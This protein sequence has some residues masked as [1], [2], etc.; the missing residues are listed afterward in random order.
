MC[1]RLFLFVF[2]LVT[3]CV[4]HRDA[5]PTAEVPD[6]R[7]VSVVSVQGPPKDDLTSSCHQL[8]KDHLGRKWA[9][10]CV[11]RPGSSDY[12]CRLSCDDQFI[13]SIELEHARLA[14]EFRLESSRAESFAVMRIEG[15][16]GTGL[17][18]RV[19]HWYRLRARGIHN[20]GN[21]YVSGYVTG[22]GQ[23]FDRE[24]RVALDLLEDGK[25]CLRATGSIDV[26]GGGAGDE[27]L[28]PAPTD[29]D[30][31]L[32]FTADRVAEYRWDVQTGTFVADDETQAAG[33]EQMMTGG[34]DYLVEH[35]QPELTAYALKYGPDVCDW[36]KWLRARCEKETNR[37]A[38]AALIEQCS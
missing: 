16:H 17:S 24:F 21:F 31:G 27:I 15:M 11:T 32:L 4:A 36:L 8:G 12:V 35:F 26:S 2:L 1:V 9:I 30:Q 28:A 7:P 6:S 38:V 33:V 37:T 22:W 14:P 5:E 19:E 29:G 25:L 34:C 3:G 18:S 20:V 13:E 23:P 10:E